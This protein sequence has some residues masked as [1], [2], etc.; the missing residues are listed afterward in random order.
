MTKLEA[1]KK[2]KN[3]NTAFQTKKKKKFLSK[4]NFGS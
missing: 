3:K 2:G 1:K 4:L